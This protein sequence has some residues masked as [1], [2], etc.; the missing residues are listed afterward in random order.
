[1]ASVAASLWYAFRVMPESPPGAGPLLCPM[2]GAPHEATAAACARCGERLR[3]WLPVTDKEVRWFRGQTYALATAW[4]LLALILPTI[5]TALASQSTEVAGS[6]LRVLHHLAAVSFAGCAVLGF[7]LK[8]R[9]CA[10]GAWV[11]LLL[12]VVQMLSLRDPW[13]GLAVIIAPQSVLLTVCFVLRDRI[14]ALEQRILNAG[15]PVT[16]RPGQ[17][18]PPVSSPEGGRRPA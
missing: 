12:I 4:V 10:R 6:V 8:A 13:P 17:Q 5:D 9:V 18:N 7:R 15:L 14:T 2:C 16:V 11:W 1:M 3:I